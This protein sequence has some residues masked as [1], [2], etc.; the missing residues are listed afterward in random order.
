MN[1]STTTAFG[2]P[3]TADTRS[4]FT[5]GGN[6]PGS[7]ITVDVSPTGH[8]IKVTG[9]TGSWD[10]AVEARNWFRGLPPGATVG[11]EDPS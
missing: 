4:S 6:T 2:W 1:S 8:V 7:T 3:I 9:R 11:P 5:V 10:V